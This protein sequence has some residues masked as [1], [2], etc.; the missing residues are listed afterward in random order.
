MTYYR[1]LLF[2]TISSIIIAG[3]ASYP[4]PGKPSGDKNTG[5]KSAPEFKRVS[6]KDVKTDLDDER[7]IIRIEASA[8]FKYIAYML[9][10]PRRLA[11]EISGAYSTLPASSILV[12]DN[13][14]KRI[15]V[16]DFKEA[17][18]VRVEI[19]LARPMKHDLKQKNSELE[20]SFTPYKKK[21]DPAVMAER[22]LRAHKNA[23]RLEAEIENL[24]AQLAELQRQY[25]IDENTIAD[26]MEDINIL[27]SPPKAQGSTGGETAVDSGAMAE[28]KS[29]VTLQEK[30]GD[31]G[32]VEISG[33]IERWRSAWQD[34]DYEAY[35]RFYAGVF[36]KKDVGLEEWLAV[37]KKKFEKAKQISVEVVNLNITIDDSQATAEFIQ[38]YRSDLY[39]DT[40]VKT[41]MLVKTDEGWK[42]ESE[43]WRP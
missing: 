36:S 35:A 2:F 27:K 23:S 32:A 22:L 37:K 6:I 41:L 3:C 1:K 17:K 28:Q 42:I 9:E 38:H 20:I 19:W 24:K 4:F 40:G 25:N 13:V 18:A 7:K 14:I 30:S 12:V 39:N 29:E 10:K 8:P 43:N 21:N 11:V 16:L 33:M 31:D 26:L 34:R 5:R 15:G